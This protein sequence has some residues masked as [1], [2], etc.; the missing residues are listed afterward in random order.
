M[1]HK[2]NSPMT[3]DCNPQQLE[4]QGV[5]R[6][7]VVAAFDGGTLT[8]DGGLLLLSEV[9]RRRG[10]LCQFA[11]CFRDQRNP[12]YVEH[13]VEELV[14]QRVLG[15][16]LA[17][18]D[19][20]DH[21]DLRADPLLATVV[22]KADPTGNDRRQE[23]DRG[24]PLA[25]KSTLN[26]LEWGAV[27]QDRYRKI[28]VDTQAVDRFLVDTFLSAHESVPTQIILDLDATDDPL[29][30]EQ[31]GRFFHGYYG[32]YCY[33]PLYIFCG[34]HLLC[35]LLRSSDRD[36][37][38]GAVT[39]VERIVEQIRSRWPEVQIILR[40]DSGF[41]REELMAWCEQHGVD[42]ILGLARNARLQRALGGELAQAREQFEQSGEATRIFRDFS[43]RT[44][45]S[46]SCQRRV[47]GK[48]EHL[49]KGANPRFVVTSLSAESWPA[50]ALYEQLYCARGEMENRIKEQQLCLFADRTSSHN[51]ASNQLR[52]WFSSVAYILLHE[53]RRLGL[54]G[55]E[56]ARARCDT[57]RTK[58]LKIGAQIRVTVRRV[59][60]HLA[61]S[62]P[63]ATLW[64]QIVG[65]LR[66]GPSPIG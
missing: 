45:K 22:G 34:A 44:R 10:I 46:W 60:V 66:S 64:A 42:Y 20:N 33:L 52:L 54:Q 6:R 35:A 5:G 15:L 8:S 23:Q 7:T 31:E 59:W 2:E 9:E 47:I 56:L 39:E 18:E 16:A 48:A 4:F 55:T 12:A 65:N 24:K 29:H 53:L 26:R 1:T 28:S 61:S 27:K 30:G 3:T 19:L 32:G 57:I 50:T 14:R 25:G 49:A 58:L 11:A 13:S 51:L 38:A 62:Y 17:Y 40:A 41:A 63:Y 37:S 21:E 43:Y 36:A